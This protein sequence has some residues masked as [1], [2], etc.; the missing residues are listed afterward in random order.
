MTQC[1][2][3][4]HM[5]KKLQL[6]N[7]G[8]RHPNINGHI[9]VQLSW[10]DLKLFLAV[11][12][13]GSLSAAARS[14]GLGQATLS[15][16]MAELETAAGETF[17]IRR[18]QGI[19]LTEAGRRLLPAVQRMAEFAAEASLAL[20]KDEDEP[21]GVVRIAAPPGVAQDFLAPFAGLLMSRFP[22]IQLQVLSGVEV[23]NLSR[24]EAD[25]SIRLVEPAD[26]ELICLEKLVAPLRVFVSREYGATLPANV[27]LSDL[28]W[29]SWTNPFVD[30]C[31]Q[32]ELPGAPPDLRPFFS[33]DDHNVQRAACL[34]GVGAMLDGRIIH[35]FSMLRELVELDFDF[36]PTAV[37]NVYLVCHRRQRHL[38]RVRAVIDML[39]EEFAFARQRS[40]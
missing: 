3:A 33:S 7:Y 8:C 36:G 11:Q 18:T 28:R 12:E 32:D 35:R 27:Q 15:R 1:N 17:F 31:V 39:R 14:L 29:I 2:H 24:G 34:A 4:S 9:A 38:S 26:P 22:K 23:L 25:L 20:A 30:P 37:F 19:E 5:D 13:S 21:A 16:R 10:D 40:Q 6:P